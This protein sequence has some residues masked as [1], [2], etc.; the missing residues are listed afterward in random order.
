MTRCASASSSVPSSAASLPVPASP[1]S[2]GRSKSRPMH[3]AIAS[4]AQQGADSRLSRWP[5]TARMPLGT[6]S[7]SAAAARG[8]SPA[9]PWRMKRSVSTRNSGLPSVRR[10][11]AATTAAGG[12]TAL[13]AATRRSVSS[14][15]RPCSGRRLNCR[16]FSSSARV[17][18]SGCWRDN[19]AS[20][21]EPSSSMRHS[22]M[23]CA[24]K[25]SRRSDDASAQCR[26]SRI[27]SSGRSVATWRQTCAT[28]ANSRKRAWSPSPMAGTAVPEGSRLASSGAISTAAA[29]SRPS[30]AGKR[31]SRQARRQACIAR[32]HGRNGGAPGSSRQRPHNANMPRRRASVATSCARRVL[33]MPA[34]PLST[35]TRPRPASAPPSASCNNCSSLRRPTNGS[36][37]GAAAAPAIGGAPQAGHGAS[38]PRRTRPQ[39]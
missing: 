7:T 22:P 34:S 30:S 21:Q 28:A 4:S 8:S 35:T 10:W 12:V 20:R 18:A 39:R 3:A 1:A 11:I 33:P 38:A 2:N 36:V 15:L 23:S 32:V 25:A 31:S 29:A 17:A 14:K 27:S 9:C 16:V 13:A 6:V 26:L 19:P 24:M 5:I 37:A